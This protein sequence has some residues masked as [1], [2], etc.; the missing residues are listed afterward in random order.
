MGWYNEPTKN[1][2]LI[3]FNTENFNFKKKL[4]QNRCG[5]FEGLAHKRFGHLGRV[6]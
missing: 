4:F 5:L 1:T 3:D 2:I 6:Q